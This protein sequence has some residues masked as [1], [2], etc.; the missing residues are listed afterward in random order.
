MKQKLY[1]C[2]T[3][4][5]MFDTV[6]TLHDCLLITLGVISTMEPVEEKLRAQLVPEM[7]ATDIAEYLVRKG[8]PFR[9]THYIAGG[10]VKMAEDRGVP[11]NTLTVEDLKVIVHDAHEQTLSPDYVFTI[12]LSLIPYL[13]SFFPHCVFM[14]RL[15]CRHF[16]LNLP[17]TYLVSGAM[18][19]ALS[20]AAR[21][22]AHRKQAF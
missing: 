11:L 15:E 8:V 6:S 2:V 14:I 9:E 21:L 13:L 1:L 19:I 17:K 12:C 10:A 18:K 3:Q 5:P 22:E 4:E 16:I 20:P 7:L